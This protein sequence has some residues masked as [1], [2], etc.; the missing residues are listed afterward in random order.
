MAANIEVYRATSVPFIY[1]HTDSNGDAVSLEGCT[2]YFTVKTEKYDTDANDSS[3]IIS[4]TVSSHTG[5]ISGTELNAAGGVSGFILSDTDTYVEPGKY[6]YTFLVENS[7]G[8]AEPPSVMG[9][10]RVLPQQTNRNVGNE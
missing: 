2:L 7:D 1:N 3:A 6:F 9:T 10:F 4:K 8:Q 5:T